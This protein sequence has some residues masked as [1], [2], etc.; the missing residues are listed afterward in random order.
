MLRW[1]LAGALVAI[2]ADALDVVVMNYVDLGGGGIR[3]YHAFDKWTDLFALVTFFVVSLRWTG[4]DR[5]IAVVLFALR[6]LGVALFEA[7]GWR[8]ALI[9]LPNLFETWFLYVCL[10]TAWPATGDSEER[11]ALLSALVGFKL[12]QEVAIHGF[13][14]LDR[15]NLAEVVDRLRGGLR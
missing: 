15:Y 12:V 2:A 8:G 1:P 6:L 13:Q 14:V 3:D 11:P 7:T 9:G 10:R 4:R 5:T